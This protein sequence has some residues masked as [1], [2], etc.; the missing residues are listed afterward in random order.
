YCQA[1]LKCLKTGRS[2]EV[3]M[4]KQFVS[5]LEERIRI[6]QQGGYTAN[7][8]PAKLVGKFLN[9]ID[10]TASRVVGGMPPP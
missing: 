6:H 5:S 3:G 4:W 9:F 1:V 2:P 7:L 10:S 8:A